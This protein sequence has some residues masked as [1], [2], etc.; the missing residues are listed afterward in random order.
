MTTAMALRWL[1]FAVGLEAIR[2][3]TRSKG[4]WVLRGIAIVGIAVSA[5]MRRRKDHVE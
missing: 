2:D 3:F 1:V 5:M 4:A